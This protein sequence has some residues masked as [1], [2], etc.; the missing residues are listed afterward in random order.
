MPGSKIGKW[1]LGKIER[2]YVKDTFRKRVAK[3][4]MIQI[5][6]LQLAPV[7]I[8]DGSAWIKR[9]SSVNESFNSHAEI[10]FILWPRYI[11]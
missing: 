1:H 11:K 10:M 6:V 3:V 4:C 9:I 8:I 2:G 5:P 7:S